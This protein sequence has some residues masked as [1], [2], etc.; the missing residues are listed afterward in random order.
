MRT[1]SRD[2]P[3]VNACACWNASK[4][5][6]P[7]SSVAVPH[8]VISGSLR[9]GLIRLAPMK[10]HESI[11]VVHEA[12][13]VWIDSLA[14]AAPMKQVELVVL[15]SASTPCLHIS[16]TK[17]VTLAMRCPIPFV[18]TETV[19]LGSTCCPTLRS[20]LTL[21]HMRMGGRWRYRAEASKE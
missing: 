1:Y 16:P 9:R 3:G 4:G 10:F 13:A 14:L 15:I 20:E 21:H 7:S 6:G 19:L 12:F 2:C 18:Q 11:A 8:A 5:N 17:P